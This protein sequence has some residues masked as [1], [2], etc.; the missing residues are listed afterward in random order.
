MALVPSP[1]TGQAWGQ[2]IAS[3]PTLWFYVPYAQTDIYSMEFELW[4][5]DNNLI[6]QDR[7]V[8]IPATPGI[9]SYQVAAATPLEVG[10]TYRWYLLLRFD[11]NNPSLDE[12]VSG[13]I[14]RI[15]AADLSGQLEAA[16]PLEQAQLLAEAGVWYD[17]LT[18]LAA[19]Q[20]EQPEIWSQFLQAVGLSA[21][22]EEPL[23][24]AY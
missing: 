7:Q 23:V 5:E 16:L 9:T 10:K 21:I 2:T 4:D 19:V 22:A 13:R 20:A 15:A 3:A 11:P 1:E 14:E 17:T 6:V 24:S 12:Y 18:V 8:S